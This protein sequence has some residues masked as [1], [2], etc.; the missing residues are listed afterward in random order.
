MFEIAGHTMGTPEY[1]VTE[2]IDL[3]SSIG[4][5]GI[6]IVVQDGYLS[7][8]PV[9]ASMEELL[10]IKDHA[11]RKN[12][13]IIC[14]TPY[15]ADYNSLDDAIRN[16]AIDGLRKVIGY[17][18]L[19]GARYVR[20]YGGNEQNGEVSALASVGYEEKRRRLVEAMRLL[21]NE[22]REVGVTL[23][24]ENHFNTMTVSAAQSVAMQQEINHPNVGILYD[25]ANLAFTNNEHYAEAISLQREF[26]KYVHVKDLVFKSD[27]TEFT[28]SDVSHQ[29]ESERNVTTRIVGEGVLEWPQ[30][31]SMLVS[32]GYGGWLSL[33]YERRWHA[34]DIPDARI[35]MKQSAQYIRECIANL[36]RV[37]KS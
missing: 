23:V 24:I 9:D 8:I 21:G 1:S 12:L 2:A 35:G 22:A 3:F 28:S 34:Q 17:A 31:L 37:E 18:S 10:S 26:I 5:D 27:S 32:N 25:Q 36:N 16:K 13:R 30:I 20:I 33:E 11:S 15:Y 14:L 7:G 6:E 29:K 19:L 4:L